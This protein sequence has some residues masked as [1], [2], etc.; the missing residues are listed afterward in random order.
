MIIKYCLGP[1]TFCRPKTENGICKQEA[2]T[3][4]MPPCSF[5][6]HIIAPEEAAV[7]D[8]IYLSFFYF[9]VPT[10]QF[11]G[12]VDGGG[13]AGW[14]QKQKQ[15]QKQR[16]R[17]RLGDRRTLQKGAELSHTAHALLTHT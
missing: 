11:G 9:F 7:A 2:T 13:G 16:Q 1:Q 6:M 5:S 10:F 17:Q 4:R 15:S 14:M 12:V 3:T 8:F